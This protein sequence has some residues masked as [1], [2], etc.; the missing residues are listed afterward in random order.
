MEATEENPLFLWADDAKHAEGGIFI[1]VK[2]DLQKLAA[3][4]PIPV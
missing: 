2:T 3:Q 4:Y 1:L